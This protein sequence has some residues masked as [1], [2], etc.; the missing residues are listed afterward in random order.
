M[1]NLFF[2][3]EPHHHK[4]TYLDWQGP[5]RGKGIIDV[6]FLLS[7][8]TQTEVRSAH[9]KELIHLSVNALENQGVKNYTFDQAWE[10][11]RVGVLY[12]WCFVALV[13]G[14]LDPSNERGKAWMTEM[15]KR[16]VLA[17]KELNC[18]ELL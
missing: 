13:T 7:Q 5:V 12:Q 1:D 3:K 9:D 11:Y 14:S 17:I 8:S 16:N 6:A 15:V 2:G 10:D 4:V 18:L